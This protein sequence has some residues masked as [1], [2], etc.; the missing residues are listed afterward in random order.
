[1]GDE[2]SKEYK[3]Y[4]DQLIE[5]MESWKNEIVDLTSKYS[6]DTRTLQDALGAV[7]M[8]EKKWW[9][10]YKPLIIFIVVVVALF[11]ISKYA[12]CGEYTFPFNFGSFV[13]TC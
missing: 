6:T 1:M 10:A 5:K 12:G 9:N 7:K 3:E 8:Q 11:L 4:L 2:N 13:R